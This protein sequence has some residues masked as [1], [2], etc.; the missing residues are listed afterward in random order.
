M[1]DN[2]Q[3]AQMLQIRLSLDFGIGY[4]LRTNHIGVGL[5][6]DIFCYT[7]DVKTDMATGASSI[8]LK[9]CERNTMCDPDK[10]R[11]LVL[12]CLAILVG[13]MICATFSVDDSQS[14]EEQWP[15]DDLSS[16]KSIH[17]NANA[18]HGVEANQSKGGEW[19]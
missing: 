3:P 16:Y 4:V 7:Q 18:K 12:A 19:N 5:K 14:P 13:A 17:A 15:V 9:I 11:H 1:S 8:Q 2:R 10:L 6:E